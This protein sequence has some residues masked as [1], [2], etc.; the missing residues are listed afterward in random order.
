MIRNEYIG[1]S[2][3]D[4]NVSTRLIKLHVYLGLDLIDHVQILIRTVI[5]GHGIHHLVLF[6]NGFKIPFILL[7]RLVELLNIRT[8]LV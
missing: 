8:L 5:L 1:I 3:I 2:I 7:L 4:T 6:F